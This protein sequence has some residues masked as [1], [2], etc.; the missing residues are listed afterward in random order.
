MCRAEPERGA[1][2]LHKVHTQTDPI[3]LAQA[4]YETQLFVEPDSVVPIVI[5]L[6]D[7]A[8]EA[9]L[10]GLLDEPVA[11]GAGDALAT[12][13]MMRRDAHKLA[14]SIGLDQQRAGAYQRFSVE[15][16]QEEMAVREIVGRDIVEVR[17]ERLVDKAKA[18]A[19][20]LQN[21][22]ARRLLVVRRERPNGDCCLGH[23]LPATSL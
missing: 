19:Q 13:S 23:K 12:V 8:G 3:P 5:R 21:Q 15:S 14:N 22:S 7:Q 2:D 6:D 18:V 1:Q 17:I 20:T 9:V 16:K 4:F 11:D 10:A